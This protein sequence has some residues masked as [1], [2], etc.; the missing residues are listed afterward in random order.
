MLDVGESAPEFTLPKAGGDVYNDIEPFDL[1]DA[2]GDGPVV[3]AFF[4]AA[5]TSGCTAEMC[6]FRDSMHRFDDLDADVYGISVD[7]PPAQNVW[8]LREELDFPMLSDWD[9]EVIHDYGVIEPEMYGQFEAARRS[10]FVLDAAGTVAYRWV[11]G[12]GETDF[13]AVVETV[14]DAVAEVA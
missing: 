13:E 2:L 11:E 14:R 5:F 8:I 4:P 9:H 1:A 12:E 3:L 6:A 7:L 10:I